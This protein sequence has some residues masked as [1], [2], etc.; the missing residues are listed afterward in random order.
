MTPDE[1]L[2][3]AVNQAVEAIVLGEFEKAESA[4]V[5]VLALGTYVREQADA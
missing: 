2:D 3:C 5:L 4:V 1:L